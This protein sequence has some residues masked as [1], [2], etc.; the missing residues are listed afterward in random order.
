LTLEADLLD[1]IE[2][3][4]GGDPMNDQKWTRLSLEQLRQLLSGRGHGIDRKTVRRLLVKHGY[5]LKANRKRF[6]GPPHPHRD[7]QFRHILRYKK[8]FLREGWPVISIDAKKKELIG[9][10]K[11]AGRAWCRR[12][13][14]VNAYDFPSDALCRATPYGLYGL[15]HGR[16]YMYV[17]TSADTPEFAVDAVGRWWREVGR[18]Q[19]PGCSKVL[20]LADSGGS[21]GCR[22]RLWKMRLQERMADAYGLSVTVC[23]YPRGGSKW[24][25]VEHRLLGPIS[26][27]WAGVP[28]KT[29]AVMLA[30]I[31]GT[32]VGGQPVVADLLEGQYRTG[33]KVSD[34]EFATIRL[35]RHKTCPAWNYT[36]RPRNTQLA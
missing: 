25:P 27:N 30:L 11:N 29:L 32:T 36:I 5:S 34:N 15:N 18:G 3:E 16:G 9:D 2:H 24:N 17:G 6:T 20:L 33:V 26:I 10:F 4:T 31:R 28:L 1:L 12:A 35:L 14:E 22:P 19:F 13:K 21:N 8:F 23:H 7:A